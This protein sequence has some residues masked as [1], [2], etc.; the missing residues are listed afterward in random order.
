[1]KI[2]DV[3]GIQV[4]SNGNGSMRCKD[5]YELYKL[6]EKIYFPNLYGDKW[7]NTSNKP[8][9][10]GYKIDYTAHKYKDFLEPNDDYIDYIPHFYEV[11]NNEFTRKDLLQVIKYYDELS[12]Q[13]GLNNFQLRT[14]ASCY[15]QRR[16]GILLSLGI[17]PIT[18][19]NIVNTHTYQ[20]EGEINE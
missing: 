5:E 18:I 6:L 9:Y 15:N 14:I 8:L 17:L 3:F 1:M 19:K 7:E 2:F 10:N 4:C 13:K 20:T 11:K 16:C 12:E